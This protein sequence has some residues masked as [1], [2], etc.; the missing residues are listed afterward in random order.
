M[1]RVDSDDYTTVG[2]KRQY[3]DGSPPLTPATVLASK[4]LNAV[5]EELLKVVEDAGLTPSDADVTQLRQ[6]LDVL[7]GRLASANTW[8]GNQAIEGTLEVGTLGTPKNTTMHGD[9]QVD[10]TATVDGDL[11]V[12]TTTTVQTLNAGVTGVSSL[13]SFGAADVDGTFNADGAATFGSTVGVTGLLSADGRATL[14]SPTAATGP[15]PQTAATVKD[16][17]LAFDA[18]APNSGV[19]L[20][21]F[22][23]PGNLVKAWGQIATTGGGSSSAS[24]TGGFNVTSATAPGTSVTVTLASAVYSVVGIAMA[25]MNLDTHVVIAQVT[26]TT[27]LTITARDFGGTAYNFNSGAGRNI[28]FVVFGV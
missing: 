4:W 14:K 16:G 25:H 8:T 12:N 21:G 6:A 7:Y 9:L 19:A 20:A 26:G 18:T 1:D 28:A 13:H 11:N 5:Q 2:G 23:T 15:T 17:Y 10:G 24:V 3:T 27:S 22:L